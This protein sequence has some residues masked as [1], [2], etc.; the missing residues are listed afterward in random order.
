MLKLLLGDP[1]TRK[2]KRYQPLVEEINLLEDE[3]SKLS[4][5]NLR[6]E[7]NN[8]KQII[9]AESNL[10]KQNELIGDVLPKAFAIVRE[11]SKR[12]LGMR[13]FDVQ[14]IGGMVL[15]ECQIAEMKTGEG[16]TLVATLPCYLNALSGRGV[17][18]VTVNDYLARRDAE[19]MGQ[20]HK[21][22]G[23]SVGLIQQDMTPQQRKKNY[24]CDITYATNSELGFD[25]LRDN[26]STDIDEV[27]Q[28]EFNYC[29]ID[30]VDSILIDEARTPLIISGQIERPQEK[31]QKAAELSLSLTRAE[32][33]SKDGIDPEGDYE[34]DE[35]QRSC[36]LTDQGFAKCE[37]YLKI[38]DLYDPQDP[39]AHYV[40]NALK[41]KELFIKDV[42]YIIKNNEAVIVDEFTG[43]VMPGRRWSDGQHQA[44][45][46][47][48]NLPIQP[49]TQTL[50]SITYQNF[51]LLYPGLAGMTGTAKTEEVEF[52]KTYKLQST[53]VPT[54]MS[55][56]RQDW[57]DQVFKTEIG[58]WRA[59]ANE[60]AEI[61][62]KG[63]PVLV[64]TT[65]VEKS[66][67]LSSLLHEKQI[68]HNLLNAKPEN[69]EREAE[70]VA[71]A[72]RSGAVTIATNMAG[73]GTDIILGGNSDYMARLKLK[74]TLM[75][76]LV[77]PDNAHKPPIPKQR[78]SKS[79]G[80]FSKSSQKNKETINNQLNGVNSLFPCKLGEDTEHK[81]SA[82]SKQLV[83]AWGDRQLSNIDLDDRIAT[84]AEKA[85]TDDNLISSLREVLSLVR[86]EYE[87]VLIQE[88]E[89]VRKAGGLH[90][91]GTERHE[92]RRVD[93]QLRGRA[94]RQGDLGSTRFFLSL[95]DNLLRIFGGERVANL[96]NAFRVDEDMPIESGMLTRSLE[97]AQKK[98]ETYYY[99]IRKQV[100][101][102]DEVMNN[103]RKAV[104]TERLR[105]L[106]GIDLKKQV[107]GYGEVTMEEIVE[108]YVNQDLPPEEW[109]LEQL[110]SKVKEFVYLLNDLKEEDIFSLSVQELKSYLQEQLRVAYDLKESQIE[111]YRSGLMR[112]AE[113]FFI[114]QQIDNLWR[115]H[116]QAMDSLRESVGLRG[117][118]QKDPLI[119]YKNEGYD[120]FLE[121]MTNMRRN[122]IY[123]MFMFQ[124]K[125]EKEDEA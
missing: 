54:N 103:Q 4:D 37:D 109:D 1:N 38:A 24:A 6:E 69:V 99:D 12:V 68:P 40:T 113:R 33:M 77:K 46:A 23:L 47:K 27:V 32:E 20:V 65:S 67:L 76:L 116:L 125:I 11:A 97:S 25:Y 29:V 118:G 108:A 72:G 51:F 71:Q 75:P 86:S 53:V 5:D 119:E 64:G 15:H 10:Q 81:L 83:D 112:E 120:M 36:I 98:V 59:V 80:G 89:N 96:M 57:A 31:Y 19:W 122:V 79:K 78:P 52:E 87:H 66:E 49:E 101:E 30:E 94:G 50:A 22:L 63:R 41:A 60:T 18:V 28:R 117:Y 124:P 107:L 111:N 114:L 9:Q 123:S 102:Y 90:V 43:R 7:T 8:L 92:S 26:M 62:K 42:N 34:V 56:Q 48:E 55:R 115:E 35:K 14:L 88:E 2:L 44:I 100:F 85:P 95:E 82:L 3:V 74:E 84:A 21:F 13:H 110:V 61:H 93:N 39:W 17:H 104:Y 121:M 105:V 58:K 70:I 73:R 16:K 45:E 106:K 91:I